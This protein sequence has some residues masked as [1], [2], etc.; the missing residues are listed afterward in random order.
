M[1][2]EIKYYLNKEAYNLGIVSYEEV[3]EGDSCF[4]KHQAEIK[5]RSTNYEFYEISEI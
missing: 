3:V 1:K 4:A 5:L 2:F